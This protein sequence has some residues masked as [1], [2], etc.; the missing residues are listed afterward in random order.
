MSDD[1]SNTTS[2]APGG[3]KRRGSLYWAKSGWRVRLTVD[4]DGVAVQKSFDLETTDK[5][6]ARIKQRRLAKQHAPAAVLAAE[7]KRLETVE[8]ASRRVLDRQKAEGLRTWK[9]REHRLEE[10]VF[11]EIG[12]L[13]VDKVRAADIRGVLEATK[14]LGKSRQTL[15]HI[16][17]DLSTVFAELWRAEV[18]PE[19]PV[20]RV[21]VPKATE[22]HRERA[23]LTDEEL[24]RYLGWVHPDE[25]F[26][27]AVLERQTMACVARTFGGLRTR[28]LHGLRW[29]A[30]D[31]PEGRF[32]FGWAPRV[33]GGAPQLLAVPDI[34]RPILRDWWE[35]HGRPLQGPIF[36]V[37]R[38][39]RAGTERAKHSHAHA[40][41]RDLE[42]ARV[43][44]HEP[45]CS[46][47]DGKRV[48]AAG[49][50]MGEL[51]DGNAFRKPVDFHSWRRAYNQ[52]LAEANVNAQQ[53]KALAGHSTLEA[54]QR[55]LANTAKMR[56]IPT[57]ALPRL[58][59]G[60]TTPPPVSNCTGHAET[61]LAATGTDNESSLK[62]ALRGVPQPGRGPA[63]GAGCCRFKSC[64]PDRTS[65][66]FVARLDRWQLDRTRGA[67]RPHVEPPQVF[68]HLSGTRVAVLLLAPQHHADDGADRRPQRFGFRARD[69]FFDLT[70]DVVVPERRVDRVLARVHRVHE[71]PELIE[72]ALLRGIAACR[73][74]GSH[75]P[76]LDQRGPHGALPEELLGNPEIADLDRDRQPFA[77]NGEDVP[78]MQIVVDDLVVRQVLNREQDLA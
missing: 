30:L 67:A 41:R 75:Q 50:R 46:T 45:G 69:A 18:I 22:D 4:I 25:R 8:E 23:V 55:Y 68:P 42:R 51:L 76:V 57:E 65:R 36:P 71:E 48:C 39:K 64:H 2:R 31:A 16:K 10:Y 70:N 58:L 54:H 15:I 24:V 77:L 29:E 37:R 12:P 1:Q 20:D 78:R 72:I 33:K 35:R 27:M 56:T 3:R 43:A 17:T 28:E 11:P 74:L 32:A 73:H 19:N 13:P 44:D 53:A 59:V 7:A 5:A 63:L 49:C 26:R 52:A 9:D 47:A 21:V 62:K 14:D 6:V 40:F 66:R 38:G 61:Q 34:L 60:A